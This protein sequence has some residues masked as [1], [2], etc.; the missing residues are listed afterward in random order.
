MK[1]SS[2][3]SFSDS[4]YLGFVTPHP[5]HYKGWCYLKVTVMVL[6]VHVFFD[7]V[8]GDSQVN[9]IAILDLI[10]SSVILHTVLG[11]CV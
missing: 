1:W 3:Q 5:H 9:I 2:I 8:K 7:S 6:R 11:F 10:H 4:Q